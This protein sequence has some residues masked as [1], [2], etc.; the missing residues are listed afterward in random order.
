MVLRRL[1]WYS[2]TDRL[3][4]RFR[5]VEEWQGHKYVFFRDGEKADIS[6]P[7]ALT[8]RGR[9]GDGTT[10]KA[11]LGQS[12]PP[13]ARTG[14]SGRTRPGGLIRKRRLFRTSGFFL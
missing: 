12:P 9:R 2:I 6:V 8:P 7:T 3:R 11:Y 10:W 5:P 4:R 14:R 1:P 13:R